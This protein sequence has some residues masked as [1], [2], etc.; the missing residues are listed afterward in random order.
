MMKSATIPSVLPIAAA[1]RPLDP[2]ERKI[3]STLSPLPTSHEALP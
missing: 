1:K 3:P 2:R